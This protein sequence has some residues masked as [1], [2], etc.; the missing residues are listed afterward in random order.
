MTTDAITGV[1]LIHTEDPVLSELG[2]IFDDTKR[3]SIST[4]IRWI[5]HVSGK[6]NIVWHLCL[7][8][9][10]WN[11]RE[12]Y[13]E[14]LNLQ[15]DPTMNPGLDSPRCPRCLSLLNPN[16]DQGEWTIT[17]VVHDATG[18]AGSGIGGMLG[19]IHGFNTGIPLLQISS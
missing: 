15:H 14:K 8:V 3:H 17:S 13:E 4:Q 11:T 2:L 6:S 12:V 10:T 16:S 1:D 9:G 19:A 7:K 18:V 5:A